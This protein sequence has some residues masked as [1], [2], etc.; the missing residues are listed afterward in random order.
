MVNPEVLPKKKKRN[1]KQAVL[2]YHSDSTVHAKD[3]PQL[4]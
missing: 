4:A 2:V 3:R 1:K